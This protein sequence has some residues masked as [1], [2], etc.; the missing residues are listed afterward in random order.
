MPS[1]AGFTRIPVKAQDLLLSEAVLNKAI[2]GS[3]SKGASEGLR[4]EDPQYALSE[5]FSVTLSRTRRGD[6]LAITALSV[7]SMIWI[8][9]EIWTFQRS[10]FADRAKYIDDFLIL[11]RDTFRKI[12]ITSQT[13]ATNLEV[14]EMM[15]GNPTAALT[16]STELA[17]QLQAEGVTL[18][19]QVDSLDTLNQAVRYANTLE[20]NPP[21][22]QKLNVALE[23]GDLTVDSVRVLQ[24]FFEK[25]DS[26]VIK[27]FEKDT[28][29]ILKPLFATD[30]IMGIDAALKNAD[31]IIAATLNIASDIFQATTPDFL[32]KTSKTGGE[33][34][35]GL[36]EKAATIKNNATILNKQGV[37]IQGAAKSSRAITK[38]ASLAGK[39]IAKFFLVDTVWWLVTLAV[40]V[41][42]NPFLD[43]EDQ[44]IPYLSDIPWVGTLFDF[45]DK[46]GSSPLGDL[47]LVPLFNNVLKLFGIEDEAE[48]L[49]DVFVTGL[50][51]ATQAPVIG[52]AMIIILN[53]LVEINVDVEVDLAF[54]VTEFEGRLPLLRIQ[55]PLRILEVFLYAIVA[56]IVFNAW[57]QPAIGFFTKQTA[58]SA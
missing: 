40:D 32:G 38:T 8:N 43:E 55:D 19:Q 3:I 13:I 49:Y 17:A 39:G 35:E 12:N 51:A 36:S 21:L 48:T 15:K 54:G 6:Q 1:L 14:L 27:W 22:L 4:G 57:V 45:S 31:E 56:K 50:I 9:L 46:A 24:E 26:G 29:D 18:R 2:Q 42:L 25:I 23:G 5:E 41:G 16:E 53:T 30:D 10:G 34:I 52:D 37:G 28:V 44:K 33:I 20:V 58:I 47:F 7:S 11:L